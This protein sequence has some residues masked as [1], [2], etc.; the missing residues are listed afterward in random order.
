MI[1]ITG[2]TPNQRNWTIMMIS[3]GTWTIWGW[4]V[5]ICRWKVTVG[6]RSRLL[7]PYEKTCNNLSN[8][9]RSNLK[10]KNSNNASSCKK[11]TSGCTSRRRKNDGSA[12]KKRNWRRGKSAAVFCD[13]TAPRLQTSRSTLRTR[14]GY[15]WQRPLLPK[16][17]KGWMVELGTHVLEQLILHCTIKVVRC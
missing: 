6:E 17:R 7:S 13:F 12:G 15:K 4:I 9:N 5:A 1:R 8:H 14:E 16:V 11:S 3:V 10:L 2:S